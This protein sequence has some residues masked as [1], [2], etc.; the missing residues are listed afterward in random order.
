MT[1]FCKT[2]IP[3][4]IRAKLETI[5]DDDTAVKAYG[6]ELGVEMCQKLLDKGTPGLH[7][8]SL[9]MSKSTLEILKKLKLIGDN[10]LPRKLPWRTPPSAKRAEEMVRPIFW[11]NRPKSYIKRTEDWDKYACN[12]WGDSSS[13]AYGTLSDYPFMRPHTRHEKRLQK[14]REAWGEYLTCLDDVIQVFIKYTKGEISILPWNEMDKMQKESEHI[15]DSLVRLNSAGF[16]TINSQPQVNGASS[17]DPYVGWGGSDGV[18]YQ[19][20]YVEFFVSPED[21]AALLPK[22]TARPSLTFMAATSTGELTTNMENGSVN[23]VTWGVFPQKEIIQPTVV[24][25]HSFLVWKDEAFDLW[26]TEWGSLYEA[27]SRS[28][29]ILSEIKTHW[30]LVSLVENNFRTGDI[31][32]VFP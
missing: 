8:Y 27:G 28:K 18:V 19:K 29:R 9:N 26:M 23:A 32:A 1:N 16:L 3:D 20:A 6:I 4:A 22:I 13:P 2:Y 14:A 12:R 30:L 25:V 11:S 31:F 10:K 21:F 17:T 15:S 7:I 5:K 24:D